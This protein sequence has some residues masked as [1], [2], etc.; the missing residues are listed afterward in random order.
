MFMYVYVCMYVMWHLRSTVDGYMHSHLHVCLKSMCAEVCIC[1]CMYVMIWFACLHA[2]AYTVCIY[3]LIQCM[4][5]VVTVNL[6]SYRLFHQL[7][8]TT[9]A[10]PHNKSVTRLNRGTK[11]WTIICPNQFLAIRSPAV[12]ETGSIAT[13]AQQMQREHAHASPVHLCSF[14]WTG[15]IIV[16]LL[17]DAARVRSPL[18]LALRPRALLNH[19]TETQVWSL[20]AGIVSLYFVLCFF[21]IFSKKKRQ[22]KKCVQYFCQPTVKKKLKKCRQSAQSHTHFPFIHTVHSHSQFRET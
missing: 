22:R 5:L 6:K 13:R 21:L 16:C 3:L 19:N 17:E 2:C 4:F 7:Y 14:V 12:R 11:T 1:I 15:R 10:S 18:D 20:L 8:L 9:T